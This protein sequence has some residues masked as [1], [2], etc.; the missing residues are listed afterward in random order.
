MKTLPRLLLNMSLKLS[1]VTEHTTLAVCNLIDRDIM[2]RAGG[3]WERPDKKL[4][5]R[6]QQ[7]SG[8]IPSD[9]PE[10]D[11]HVPHPVFI[12]EEESNRRLLLDDKNNI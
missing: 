3:K 9:T 6:Y 2:F 7:L 12:K 1:R 10:N 5:N 4:V 8:I 11:I